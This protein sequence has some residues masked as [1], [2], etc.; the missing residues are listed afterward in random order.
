MDGH[1]LIS[2]RFDTLKVL[3]DPPNGIRSSGHDYVAMHRWPRFAALFPSSTSDLLS[4]WLWSC[5][6]QVKALRSQVLSSQRL[7]SARSCHIN[8]DRLHR[9][10][11]HQQL[12]FML[13][14]CA[15]ARPVLTSFK[16]PGSMPAARL[17]LQSIP[18]MV[19]AGFVVFQ[20][21]VHLR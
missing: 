10:P 7:A 13:F 18:G 2:L 14:R 21:S 17:W 3:A 20:S 19:V 16:G 15:Y 4:A 12:P 9:P 8:E 6:S 11:F 1:G 5:Q